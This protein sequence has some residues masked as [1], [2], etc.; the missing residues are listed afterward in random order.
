M[1]KLLIITVAI[2]VLSGC[3]TTRMILHK[4][5]MRRYYSRYISDTRDSVQQLAIFE[6]SKT[7]EL[8]F[9][10]K[11]IADPQAVLLHFYGYYV[12]TEDDEIVFYIFA[13]DQRLLGFLENTET[14]GQKTGGP[15]IQRYRIENFSPTIIRLQTNLSFPLFHLF[16]GPIENGKPPTIF[17]EV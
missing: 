7:F 11:T 3:T 5:E 13:K 16:F 2:L 12:L 6:R 10:R 8:L 9:L 15:V 1:K 4:G 17:T 14:D